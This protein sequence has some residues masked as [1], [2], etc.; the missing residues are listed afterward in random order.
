[1]N[2]GDITFFKFLVMVW[3][4]W[5]RTLLSPIRLLLCVNMDDT[6]KIWLMIDWTVNNLSF[7]AYIYIKLVHPQYVI[8][9]LF[10]LTKQCSK[11]PP[12]NFYFE[13]SPRNS[14]VWLSLTYRRG[15]EKDGDADWGGGGG[16][17]VDDEKEEVISV[18][19]RPVSA[20][21][22]IHRNIV[23]ILIVPSVMMMMVNTVGSDWVMRCEGGGGGSCCRNSVLSS[24]ALWHIKFLRWRKQQH[25]SFK[26]NGSVLNTHLYTTAGIQYNRDMPL[27]P[28]VDTSHVICLCVTILTLH[29][30]IAHDSVPCYH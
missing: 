5:C 4:R 16:G 23:V 30:N 17:L 15:R 12:I 7:N 11:I 10:S 28:I 9:S 6:N 21:L 25:I 24:A 3:C 8:W 14:C 19:F 13:T 29:H 22:F 2:V 26:H 27:T 1:M 18:Q 20:L